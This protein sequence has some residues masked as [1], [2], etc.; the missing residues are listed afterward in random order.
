MS[1]LGHLKANAIAYAA[2]FVALGGTTYA[3]ATIDGSDVKNSS[4]TGKD[5]M[6]D[7]LKGS[8]ISEK[9]LDLPIAVATKSS[10]PQTTPGNSNTLIDSFPIDLPQRSKVVL[11]GT[12]Q[13]FGNGTGAG[14]ENGSTAD[15]MRCTV[16]A[17]GVATFS[18]HSF[19]TD[20]PE[21]PNF[22]TL[23]ID[24]SLNLKKGAYTIDLQCDDAQT[25]NAQVEDSDLT[26]LAFPR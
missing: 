15:R 13:L 24:G 14:D 10:S 3:A 17:E 21:D 19:N 22:A 18:N 1:L 8:D 6:K 2:L 25:G 4:L 16:D 23:S 12:L 20:V 9:S 11:T 26:V 7:S 5:V